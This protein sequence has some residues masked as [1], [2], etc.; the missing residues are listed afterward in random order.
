MNPDD[1]TPPHLLG[2]IRVPDDFGYD[3]AGTRQWQITMGLALTPTERL[4]WLD[5]KVQEMQKLVGRAR[6]VDAISS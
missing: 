3:F 6:N 1:T 4:R 5:K 2:A